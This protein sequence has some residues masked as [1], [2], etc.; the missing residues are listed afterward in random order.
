MSIVYLKLLSVS[1]STNQALITI[2]GPTAAGKSALALQLAEAFGGEIVTADSRQVYRYMDIGTDKPAPEVRRRAPHHMID[3]VDPDEAYT[4]AM[5]QE[6]AQQAI[7]EV[8]QR[9][10][11]PILA[12]GTP[13]YVNAVIE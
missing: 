1:S 9:G 3:L 6:G 7:R 11:V 13:L 10:G 8:W 12:G 2:I 4:L 5:Y